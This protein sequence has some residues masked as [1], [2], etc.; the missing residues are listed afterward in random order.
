MLDIA[1]NKTDDKIA[2]EYGASGNS[3]AVARD[4]LRIDTRKF[5]AAK[6]KPKKYGDKVDITSAGDKIET[7]LKIGY[8]KSDQD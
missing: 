8:G 5:I 4:K 1:D 3:V 2:T 7:V 6:L